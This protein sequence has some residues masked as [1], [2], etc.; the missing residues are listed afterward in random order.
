MA[1]Y[2][3]KNYYI[4]TEEELTDVADA[5]RNQLESS[6]GLTFPNG[7]ITGIGNISGG[8]SSDFSTATLSIDRGVLSS[9]V[10]YIACLDDNDNLVG[11]LTLPE[12]TK[13]VTVILY[14]GSAELYINVS[15]GT[16]KGVISGNI[17]DV[18][19]GK[20]TFIITGDCTCTFSANKS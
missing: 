4:V 12:L 10:A 11:R 5:I 16:Y 2:A 7:F 17:T 9:L 14:K 15:S 13:D 18:S 8:S 3:D 6:E 20:L 1:D 19:S